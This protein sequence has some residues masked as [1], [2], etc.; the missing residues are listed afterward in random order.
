MIEQV[1]SPMVL[2]SRPANILLTKFWTPLLFAIPALGIL[3]EDFPTWRVVFASPFFLAGLFQVSIAILELR[4]GVLRYKRF[5]NWK[6]IHEDEIVAAGILWHPFIG[7]VRL[8]RYVFPWGRIYF[9][10]DKNTESNPFRRGEFPLVRHLN[11]EELHM[12]SRGCQ[13]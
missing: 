5:I 4:G 3:V 2:R 1:N 9:A 12:A 8:N 13:N 7:Y 10:L 6:T 11:R